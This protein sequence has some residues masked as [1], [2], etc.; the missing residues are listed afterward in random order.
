V[1][2]RIH[3]RVVDGDDRN[4]AIVPQIDAPV[5]IA[6]DQVPFSRDAQSSLARLPDEEAE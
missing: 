6:H 5:E 2:Q 4:A 3:R 1:L